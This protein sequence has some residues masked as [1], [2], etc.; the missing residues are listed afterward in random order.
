MRIMKE[1]KR[2]EFE[3]LKK[4]LESSKRSNV[5]RCRASRAKKKNLKNA[6]EF[7]LAE[8][9]QGLNNHDD[10]L[11]IQFH[12]SKHSDTLIKIIQNFSDRT[13]TQST[14]H[15]RDARRKLQ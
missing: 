8:A 12:C 11:S 4:K 10:G 13:R 3:T 14:K 15:E 5:R 9:F 1:S 2:E 7:Q 6:V